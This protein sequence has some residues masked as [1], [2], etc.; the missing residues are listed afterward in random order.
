MTF[1]RIQVRS[2]PLLLK[3]DVLV[4]DEVHERHLP[5]DVLLGV[6]KVVLEKRN[7]HSMNASS[8]SSSDALKPLRV[9][10]MSATLNAS[11]FSDYFKGA[12][13]LTVPGRMFPVTLEHC[14]V[15]TPKEREER[16]RLAAE[17]DAATAAEAREHSIG[18]SKGEAPLL[19][20]EV[21]TAAT[22]AAQQSKRRIKENFDPSPYV[23]L[24]QVL[25][26]V[27]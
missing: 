13:V 26:A 1:L 27:S 16:H 24:L 21:E 20:K 25:F 23:Q 8:S 12:P 15:A 14:R 6:L 7:L 17:A 18:S 10:L 5:A 4:V 9:V 2:D 19:S 3:Y 22:A 11:L